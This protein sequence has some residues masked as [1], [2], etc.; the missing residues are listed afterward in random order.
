MIR[1][2]DEDTRFGVGS[3]RY[4][5]DSI[6]SLE[7]AISFLCKTR[8]I[9]GYKVE[10]IRLEDI[11]GN[12]NDTTTRISADATP[13]FICEDIQGKEIQRVALV[14]MYMGAACRVSVYLKG[15]TI[16][17]F[18]DTLDPMIRDRMVEEFGK[19]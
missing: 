6:H 11:D 2:I 1:K 7:Q 19:L 10:Y 13:E 15:Y 9:A 12:E 17:L 4:A 14:G 3:Y 5:S 18:L 16:H 8:D